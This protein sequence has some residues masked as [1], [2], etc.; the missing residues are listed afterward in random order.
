[1]R[2]GTALLQL[3]SAAIG[4]G[5]G[6]SFVL[7]G[8][9]VQFRR[10]SEAALRAVMVEVDANVRVAKEI[11]GDQ[12]DRHR[13]GAFK[14]GDPDPDWLRRGV[15]D[16][17]LPYLVQIL[18]HPTLTKVSDAYGALEAVPR[19]RYVRTDVGLHFAVSGWI[20]EHLWKIMHS[21]C[22]A[23]GALQDAEQKVNSKRWTNRLRSAPRRLRDRLRWPRR[24]RA[25][26][27]QADK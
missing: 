14:S 13:R 9:N 3:A 17:Q 15:W 6:G 8:V 25:S 27:Q 20:E 10:Q 16:S 24:E 26:G 22:A 18:D 12:A 4:G 23:Q 1:M 5:I 11:V 7:W 19:M 2:L 21:F